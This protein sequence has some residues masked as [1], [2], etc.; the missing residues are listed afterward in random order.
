MICFQPEGKGVQ[1]G[2]LTRARR[3]KIL[4]SLEIFSDFNGQFP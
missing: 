1:V 2:S 4:I 3:E